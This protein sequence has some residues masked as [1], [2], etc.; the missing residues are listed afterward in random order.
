MLEINRNPRL[1]DLRIFAVL[2]LMFFALVGYSLQRH[3]APS[4]LVIGLV[5]LS[6]G[7]AILGVAAPA[8]IRWFFVGW[9]LAVFPI[10]FVI[11][12]LLIGMTYY[13]LITPL[14]W[15]ARL[16]G[17]DPLQLRCDRTR[18]TFWHER[19]T[20]RPAEDYFRQF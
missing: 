20:E 8:R 10:G 1:R 13:G 19:K 5:S 7:L 12:H 11:S 15:L 3:G 4:W 16:A 14:G 6:S 9:L 18:E 17:H 2:Q